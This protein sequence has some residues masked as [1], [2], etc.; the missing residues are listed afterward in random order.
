M[1]L[2]GEFDNGR[3]A[4]DFTK[5]YNDG[6]IKYIYNHQEKTYKEYWDNGNIY[7]DA[8]SVTLPINKLS[9]YSF[10]ADYSRSY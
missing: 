5:W 6:K 1:E 10:F 8:H 2:E 7:C 3:F 4:G 9:W